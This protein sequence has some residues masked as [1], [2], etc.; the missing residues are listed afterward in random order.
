[1]ESPVTSIKSN[2]TVGKIIGWAVLAIAVFAIADATGFTSWI[3][4]PVST[5]KAKF[6]KGAA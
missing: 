2:L 3:L 6:A 4:Y 5:A 1:M